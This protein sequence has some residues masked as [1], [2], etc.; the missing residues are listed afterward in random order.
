MKSVCFY[1]SISASIEMGTR[2]PATSS[3]LTDKM[4]SLQLCDKVLSGLQHLAHDLQR[5]MEDHDSADMVF[6]LDREEQRVPAHKIILMARFVQFL[7]AILIS[8][9]ATN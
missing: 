6:V 7:S 4:C 8:N 1:F 9:R 2:V 5:L 3:S